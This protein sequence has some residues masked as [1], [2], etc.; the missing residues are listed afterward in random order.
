[1]ANKYNVHSDMFLVS[2]FPYYLILDTQTLEQSAQ[3]CTPEQVGQFLDGIS[4]GHHAATFI[5][6]DVSGDVLLEPDRE[7]LEA[8]SHQCH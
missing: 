1:M 2:P 7:M 4:L 3:D 6:Q 8:G 5:E